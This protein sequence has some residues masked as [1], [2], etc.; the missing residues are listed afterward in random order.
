MN[1]LYEKYSIERIATNKYSEESEIS[2]PNLSSI[3][4]EGEIGID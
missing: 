2:E 4:S 3:V 1:F